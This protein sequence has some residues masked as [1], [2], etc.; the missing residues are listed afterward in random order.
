MSHLKWATA[1]GAAALLL[2]AGACGH[3]KQ[4]NTAKTDF[5]NRPNDP[6]AI[7][8][9]MKPASAPAPQEGIAAAIL[10]DTSL[11]MSDPVQGAGK[12]TMPKIKVAQK[13]LLDVL[14]KFSDFAGSHRDKKI[15]VGIYD[16][17]ARKDRPRYREVIKLAPED[18]RDTGEERFDLTGPDRIDLFVTEEGEFAPQDVASLIDRT[19]FLRDGYAL[20]LAE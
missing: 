10:L 13:A 12:Q 3:D 5:Y 6:G 11:S 9:L 2:L 18:P 4:A 16:F 17:S 1:L 20:L 8:D 7:R 15:L 14:Q 19:P